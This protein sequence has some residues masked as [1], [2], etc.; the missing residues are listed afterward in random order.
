MPNQ[1]A[2]T[3]SSSPQHG[4]KDGNTP[5]DVSAACTDSVQLDD[6]II[7]PQVTSPLH[8]VRTDGQVHY[9]MNIHDQINFA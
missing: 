4:G 9:I 2:P 3:V 8:G 7:V 1:K 6:T 5:A